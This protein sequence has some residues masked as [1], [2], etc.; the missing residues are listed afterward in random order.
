M[1][2]SAAV[3][4]DTYRNPEDRDADHVA[5]VIGGRSDVSQPGATTTPV[6]L[7]GRLLHVRIGYV[8]R[9]TTLTVQVRGAAGPWRPV[10]SRRLDLSRVLGTRRAYVGFTAATG[11]SVST[12]DVLAWNLDTAVAPDRLT[13]RG[14]A[15]LRAE[16]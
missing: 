7:F 5:L 14:A 16:A 6:P 15:A 9:N 4:F 2:H 3:E 12:Q 13:P 8:P 10:L 1:T 11:V